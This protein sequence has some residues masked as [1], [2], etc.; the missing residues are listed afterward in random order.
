MTAAK[1]PTA[2]TSGWFSKR[3]LVGL[4]ILGT[5]IMLLL[6]T[7]DAL[8]EDMSTF[9][10]YWPVL[11]VALGIWRLAA[12]GFR[13]IFGPL[14]IWTIGIVFLLAELDVGSWGI[15]Q[16][17]PV[18]LVVLGLTLVS[19][20]LTRRRPRWTRLMGGGA[21]S[22]AGG[23]RDGEV[24]AVFGGAQKRIT[25]QDFRYARATAIFGGV[26]LDLT[27]VRIAGDTAMLEVTV[28]FGGVQ[29]KVPPGWTVN[30][31]ITPRFGAVENQRRDPPSGEA[32]GEL[33]VTG[34]VTFGG[35]EVVE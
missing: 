6:D 14:V 17:W 12:S 1:T 27:G 5:G 19:R 13:S 8:G 34:T 29:L 10:T 2:M 16:L 35:L 23:S 28:L 18:I 20:G 25:S 11:L 7:S 3:A 15:G 33:I 24:R 26:E 30:I 32:T 22:N 4:L 31:E 21:T 9:G